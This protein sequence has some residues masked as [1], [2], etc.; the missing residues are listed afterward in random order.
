M[1]TTLAQLIAQVES[2]GNS[3]AVR[4]EP[5]HHSAEN[6][7]AKMQE[8]A[9]CNFV[10]AQILCAMSWGSFQIMGDNLVALGL[11]VSPFEYLHDEIMQC[12]FFSRFC[13]TDHISLTLDDVLTDV[14]KRQLFARLYNGPGN[15]MAY[16][17]RIVD[18]AKAN[19]LEVVS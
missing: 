12:D 16:A 13:A 18:V 4:F 10:T 9:K 15:F 11:S 5:A 7:V 17:Q 1:I 3:L 19:G 2:N 6:F 8:L 14:S